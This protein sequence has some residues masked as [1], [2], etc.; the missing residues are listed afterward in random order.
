M[1]HFRLFSF[2]FLS[3]T[4]KSTEP[5]FFCFLWDEGCYF[6][7][8]EGEIFFS[9]HHKELESFQTIRET[10][11]SYRCHSHLPLPPNQI[12]AE[13]TS[14]GGQ[15]WPAA[16]HK[17]QRAREKRGVWFGSSVPLNP[18]RCAFMLC[19]TRRSG[20]RCDSLSGFRH[21]VAAKWSKH[22][23]GEA[24]VS[25]APRPR[26]GGPKRRWGRGSE[27]SGLCVY[28]DVAPV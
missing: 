6:S 18:V 28:I 10:Q 22:V 17:M 5:C 13:N 11:S 16:R 12:T 19:L 24:A 26:G 3:Q 20:E 23:G 14:D 8:L 21:I 25:A 1:H 27:D 9:E 2:Q 7:V 15:S 4:H